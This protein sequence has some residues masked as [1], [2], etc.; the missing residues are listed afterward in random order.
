[1]RQ[2]SLFGGGLG[3]VKIS[4]SPAPRT[5]VFPESAGVM[6][7]TPPYLSGGPIWVDAG[8]VDAPVAAV[9]RAQDAART[10]IELSSARRRTQTRIP[11]GERMSRKD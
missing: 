6:V 5:T 4:V 11:G 8:L 2:A 10:Q 7:R 1:M 9:E 3:T